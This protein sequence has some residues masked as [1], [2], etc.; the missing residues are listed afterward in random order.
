MR[1]III[2]EEIYLPE[3][4]GKQPK[5]W[6]IAYDKRFLF[7]IS[8][9]KNDGTPVYNDISECI[10][11][12][13]AALIG[14]PVA[15]YY[16]CE[17]QGRKGVLTFDFLDNE[18]G[19]PKKEEFFDGVYL[20]SQIDP[21]FKNGSLINP[22]THQ[23]YT[24]DLI[25]QSIERFGLQKDVF[26]MLIYD[27]LIG[28]RDRN[29]SNYGIIV[30]HE[31]RTIRFAPL[32]DNCTSM[33]ISM[34]DHRLAKCIDSDGIIVD[35]DHLNE[36]VHN[37]IVGKVTLD[38]FLQYKEKRIW[39]N[40]EGKRIIDLIEEKKKEILP[41][42]E[43][44]LISEEDYHKQLRKIGNEY[45]KFDVSKLNYQTLIMYLTNFYSEEIEDTMERITNVI[46]EENVD[47]ILSHYAKEL[48]AD[49]LRMAREIVLR[50]GKWMSEYYALHKHESRGKLL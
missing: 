46:N 15:N 34:V 48:P 28:N 4:V 32:Y 40:L 45:R 42:K 22:Q 9:L 5:Y 41:L 12:D 30:N 23:M 47:R 13:I 25:L 36:V 21:G 10:A 2:D 11:E 29:P 49:R 16:L 50:R 7:K 44:G 24:V 26:N 39:D 35:E 6:I 20:I 27:A 1:A 43:A 17:S 33:G 14:I 8:T 31:N 19:K 37:H 18:V 38:R 3:P